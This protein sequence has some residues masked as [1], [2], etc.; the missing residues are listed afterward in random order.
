M[1]GFHSM[2]DVV[3][4]VVDVVNVAECYSTIITRVAEWAPSPVLKAGN[5][6]LMGK[7]SSVFACVVKS[8]PCRYEC[9]ISSH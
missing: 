4:N 1:Y 5:S 7:E 9:Q 2:E 8:L 3:G 6:W